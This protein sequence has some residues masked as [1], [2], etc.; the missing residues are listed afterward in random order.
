MISLV[1]KGGTVKV[2][3]FFA[4]EIHDGF[5]RPGGRARKWEQQMNDWLSENSQA[6]VLYVHQT[7]TGFLTKKWLISVWYEEGAA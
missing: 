3:L 2:K 6:R 5:V 7:V 1:G 4:T